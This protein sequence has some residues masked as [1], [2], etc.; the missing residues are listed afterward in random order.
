MRRNPSHRINRWPNRHHSLCR[1]RFPNHKLE[2]TAVSRVE[3]FLSGV[4]SLSAEVVVAMAG[5]WEAVVGA[6]AL[7][8][9]E[10]L[11][12]EEEE[13]EEEEVMPEILE[14]DAV[15][16]EEEVVVMVEIWGQAAEV[17]EVMAEDNRSMLEAVAAS[18]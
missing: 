3:V 16:E 15:A 4:T 14:E 1:N 11:E 6:A 9:G 12:E 18:K 7:A 13:E 17:E 8:L 10:I 5:I 2:A